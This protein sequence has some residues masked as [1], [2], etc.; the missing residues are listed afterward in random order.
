MTFERGFETDPMGSYLASL[1]RVRVLDPALVLPGHGPPFR[2]GARRAASISRNKLRRLAQI[3]EMVEARER[4][5]TELTAEL[6]PT[7]T[8]GAAAALRDGGDPRRTSPTTRCG[9]SWHGTGGPTG[10]SCGDRQGV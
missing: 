1:E 4:T 7:V 9:A 3:R 5:A 2:D 8:T 10:C 6:Y